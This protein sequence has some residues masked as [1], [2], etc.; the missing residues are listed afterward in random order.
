M[1][2]RLM[3]LAT[4]AALAIF[5]GA[6]AQQESDPLLPPAPAEQAPVDQAPSQGAPATT[7]APMTPDPTPADDAVGD[8]AVEPTPM[9]PPADALI[10]A[11]GPNEMR[12]ESLIGAS[13]FS[14][15]GED[16]GKIKDILF[17]TSG[18]ATGVVLSVGGVMGIG[19][20]EVGL[21][22]QEI[23]MRPQPELVR[24]QYT[25]EQLE[26]APTFKSHEAQEAEATRQRNESVLPPAGGMAPAP[27]E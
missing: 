15:E 26:A 7:Q 9:P 18:G 20:K 12:A 23:D 14:A 13:V 21:T 17:D 4:A 27:T 24:I 25:K 6:Q 19:S 8:V 5:P 1:L 11:Q 22:W 16:V 10:E 3:L 2:T